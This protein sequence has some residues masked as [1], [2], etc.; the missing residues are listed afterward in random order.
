MRRQFRDTSSYW[1]LLTDVIKGRAH[2]QAKGKWYKGY[3]FARGKIA[4]HVR[5]GGA[6]AS[7]GSRPASKGKL[8]PRPSL[9]ALSP[10]ASVMA[11][12]IVSL[13]PGLNCRFWPWSCLCFHDNPVLC[14]PCLHWHCCIWIYAPRGSNLSPCLRLS[15]SG[16]PHIWST[17]PP[18]PSY[19][20]VCSCPC[21]DPALGST[22]DLPCLVYSILGMLE[23]FPIWDYNNPVASCADW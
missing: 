11:F 13:W 8:A 14:E 4:L 2:K 1:N 3:Q 7:Q 6:K 10:F 19:F 20:S 18:Q 17:A 21:S 22:A 23:R 9:Q 15:P 16:A 12:D 5:W